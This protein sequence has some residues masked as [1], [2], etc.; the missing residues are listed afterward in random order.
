[1]TGFPSQVWVFTRPPAILV[2][3]IA[4]GLL[5]ATIQAGTPTPPVGN[6]IGRITPAGF[7]PLNPNGG[8]I[9]RQHSV[10]ELGVPCGLPTGVPPEANVTSKRSAR[11]AVRWHRTRFLLTGSW[12]RG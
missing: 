12:A 10:S 3:A 11:R 4:G 1:M 2:A 7:N 6:R 5:A 8:L 9:A